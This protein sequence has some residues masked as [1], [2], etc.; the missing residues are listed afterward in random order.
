MANN[1]LSVESRIFILI[2]GILIA[3][4]SLYAPVFLFVI[5]PLLLVFIFKN[6][7]KDHFFIYLLVIFFLP[8]RGIDILFFKISDFLII[9]LLIMLILSKKRMKCL[10][11]KDIIIVLVVFIAYVVLNTLF[12]SH[13]IDGLV[14]LI[15][16]LLLF[17]FFLLSTV[18]ID[19]KRKLMKSIYVFIS[20]ALVSAVIGLVA[21][22]AWFNGLRF[23]GVDTFLIKIWPFLHGSELRI[24]PFYTDPNHY[25]SLLLVP[26]IFIFTYSL[27]AKLNKRD[28]ALSISAFILL[29]SAFILTISRS[30]LLA[31]GLVFLII[32]FFARKR[33]ISAMWAVL[34]LLII[35]LSL[36]NIGVIGDVGIQT[37]QKYRYGVNADYDSRQDIWNSG[38]NMLSDN[39]LVGVGLNGFQYNIL[40]YKEIDARISHKQFFP[41]NI[42]LKS[43]TETGLIGFILFI[44]LIGVF[45]RNALRNAIFCNGCLSFAILFAILGL[46]VQGFF[47]DLF[48]ARHLWFVFALVVVVGN[49]GGDS[50]ES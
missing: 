21:A 36:F 25:A 7:F 12:A 48:T 16:Y 17:I 9:I 44:L 15:R 19:T 29:A 41:H 5:V 27:L 26:L 50:V 4:I 8:F 22:G 31:L 10:V 40:K 2:G 49:L 28:Y 24:M 13:F 43:L 14:Q 46:L 42:Y 32:P 30:A 34:L 39:S 38:F 6:K 37:L 18:L 47:L 20:G 11:P 3:L 33:W 1:N 45:L 23:N 35:P